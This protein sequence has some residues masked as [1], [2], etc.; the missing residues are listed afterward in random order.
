MQIQAATTPFMPLKETSAVED[1]ISSE[2][3]F[4]SGSDGESP[5]RLEYKP[6]SQKTHQPAG[7]ACGFEASKRPTIGCYSFVSTKL[8]WAFPFLKYIWPTSPGLGI[9]E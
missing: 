8:R 2:A 7:Q 5:S 4:S 3:R 1:A 6:A 9:G